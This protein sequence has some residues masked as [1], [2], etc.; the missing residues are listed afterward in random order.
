MSKNCSITIA[1]G[2]EEDLA[3]DK[4]WLSTRDAQRVASVMA[5]LWPSNM[6]NLTASPTPCLSQTLSMLYH[7]FTLSPNIH[8]KFGTQDGNMCSI[9]PDL[10]KYNRFTD[11]RG[12]SLYCSLFAKQYLN[13]LNIVITAMWHHKRVHINVLSRMG[14]LYQR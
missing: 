10:G 5:K 14:H 1:E 3:E 4:D 11:S 12:P 7:Q 8:K 13:I 9:C 6:V 2:E